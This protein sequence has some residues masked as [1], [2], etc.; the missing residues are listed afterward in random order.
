MS[1]RSTNAL[2]VVFNTSQGR[3]YLASRRG[4]PPAVIEQLSSLGISSICNILAAIK[5]AKYY[6][7]GP[8]DVVATVATD[9]AEMYASEVEKTLKSDFGGRFDAIDAA[10]AFGQHALGATTDHLIE[11]TLRERERIFNLGYFTWVEQQ[12]Y[13]TEDFRSRAKQSF[14]RG[15]QELLPAW[16]AM[17]E[18][19]NAEAAV[20][21]AAV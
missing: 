7:M 11:L 19:A 16:D 2:N 6:G 20:M 13:T 9:G 8:S 4:V 12:G 17:I 10:A 21:P 18:E 5:T 1:D 3:D 14:W 15:L